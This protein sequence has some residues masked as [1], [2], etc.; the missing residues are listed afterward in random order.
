ME[1]SVSRTCRSEREMVVN[2]IA[3]KS[4]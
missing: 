3:Y 4:R 2:A 1:V